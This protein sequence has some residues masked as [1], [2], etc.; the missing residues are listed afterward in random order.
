MRYLFSANNFMPCLT[1]FIEF[2]YFYRLVH[3]VGY[4]EDS[5]TEL[6][7]RKQYPEELYSFSYEENSLEFIE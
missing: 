2:P 3:D 6:P 1:I 5:P 4:D 7:N